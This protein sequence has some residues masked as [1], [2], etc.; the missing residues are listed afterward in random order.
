MS[1]TVAWPKPTEELVT[2]AFADLAARHRWQLG[3][4][5]MLGPMFSRRSICSL[6]RDKTYPNGNGAIA[7][8]EICGLADGLRVTLSLGTSRQKL[9]PYFEDFGFQICDQIGHG[10]YVVYV[11]TR[12]PKGN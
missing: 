5:W 2:A 12:L 4:S 7:M 6:Y 8:R 3:V 9:V 11:M 1:T 10:D